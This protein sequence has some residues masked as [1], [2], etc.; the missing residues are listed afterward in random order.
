[1][2]CFNRQGE[3]G[4]MLLEAV[5]L[6]PVVMASLLAAGQFAHLWFA[7][8]MVEYA[9]ISGARIAA[10]QP[11]GARANNQVLR[12][13]QQVCSVVSMTAAEGSTATDV[14][15]PWIGTVDGSKDV[16]RKVSVLVEENSQRYCVVTVTM[17]FPLV[18]PVVNQI[19]SGA[20]KYVTKSRTLADGT[21]KSWIELVFSND[22]AQRPSFISTPSGELFPHV[23]IRSRAVVPK[24]YALAN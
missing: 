6:F 13:A 19:L 22:P 18:F 7:R 24:P 14:V 23:S 8:H 15:L 16:N 17:K 12:A 21:E 3:S 20:M 4:S 11:V 5:L 2:K 1:M 10:V 9:A